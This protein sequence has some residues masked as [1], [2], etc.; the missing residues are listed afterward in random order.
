M[1]TVDRYVLEIDTE[2]ANRGL[3]RTQTAMAGVQGAASRLRGVIAPLAAGLAAVGVVNVVGNK[4]N[5]F[6][7]LAKAARAAGAAASEDA[8]RGFQVMKF[9]LSEAGVDA[10]TADRAFLNISQR[11]KEGAEGGKAFA[12]VFE[13][14]KGEIVGA[15]GQLKSSP[16]ILEALINAMNEGRISADE[17]QKV[18]GGR[19]GPVI[20]Q[21]FASI[22]QDAATLSATL[23][24]AAENTDIVGLDA[25]E[26]AEVFNDNI[27]RLKENLSKLLTEAITPLLPHLVE[28]SENILANMPAFIEG[29]K[30]A[31][32]ALEPVLSLVA[33]V[34]SEIVAP[35]L[36][37]ILT[38]LGGIA[39]AITPLVE[40][41]IPALQA[42]FE[43]L[44]SIVETIIGFFQST[45]ELLGQ[46]GDKAVALKNNVTGAFGSMK[47]SVVNK[48]S[49]MYNGVTGWF[50]G[51]YDYVV[52]NSVVPD[53]VKGVLGEFSFLNDGLLGTMQNIFNNV[54]SYFTDIFNTVK[55]K[56]AGIRDAL[57]GIGGGI[58]NKV[59]GAFG[60]IGDFFAGFF[61]NGG[62]I[63]G[64]KFG[65]VGER[66]PELVSG[67][68]QVTPM[69]GGV[70]YNINAVDVNSF[71]NLL[72]RDP[73]YLHALVQKGALSIPGGRR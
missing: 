73:G 10:A 63:P 54:T 9:A 4:I 6:D 27:G 44:V 5:E 70:T 69:A 68:A 62:F 28:F 18:V 48:T 26:N 47:D 33:T 13:I 61:A 55:A 46:I 58:S 35:A 64:G 56:T 20:S 49:E 19:A 7:D 51:M 34:F 37:L 2:E 31:F 3:G 14:M 30:E 41:A 52:G 25:A 1:A 60:G 43:G 38:A 36:K 40:A 59:S 57:S 39:E 8:F 23:K 66:G 11:M 22:N 29:V 16:E 65:V 21:A 24:D 71:Q 42:A 15:N 12:G 45:I 17:F 32:D 72:A 50:D 67:P 53:M